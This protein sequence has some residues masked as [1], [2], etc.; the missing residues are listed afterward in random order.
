MVNW[1]RKIW[2]R[3]GFVY[4]DRI[5]GPKRKCTKSLLHRGRHHGPLAVL[6]KYPRHD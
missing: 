6:V 3:C 5:G 2:P 4:I 1:L